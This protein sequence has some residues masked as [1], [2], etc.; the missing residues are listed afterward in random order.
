MDLITILAVTAILLSAA[1]LVLICALLGKLAAMDRQ[2]KENANEL[3]NAADTQ[4]EEITRLAQGQQYLSGRLESLGQQLMLFSANQND[5][6][7]RMDRRMEQLQG[8]TRQSLES[9][10][11]GNDRQLTEMRRTVD[12]KLTE[13]IDRRLQESFSQVSGRLEQV[14]RG[15]GEMQNLARG[16]GD[17]KTLLGNVKSRGI[18]GEMQLGA[19]MEQML[20]PGQ[21]EENCPV[22]PGASERVEFAVRLPGRHGEAILLPVDSKFPQEDYQRLTEAIDSGDAE[23]ADAARKAFARAVLTEGKRISS[24]Y[25][26]PP[27]T[28]D[29]AVMF[30]P[31]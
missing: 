16:V 26:V 29:F 24:K 2:R 13:S 25:I 5:N 4:R 8:E 21:Y 1:A 7:T 6:L 15:L 3:L 22:V 18:W 27:Y 23:A 30:L 9:I 31:L 12:E 11:T 28:T 20:T 14:Y 19:L 10:R 17:L